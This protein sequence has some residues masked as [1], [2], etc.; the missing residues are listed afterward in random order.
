VSAS[1]SDIGAIRAA[2]QTLVESFEAADPT[3]WVDSYTDDAI[4]V[5]PGMAAI[6]GREALLA[7]ARQMSPLSSARIDAR[8]TEVE[9]DM[10]A[11]LGTASWVSGPRGAE[12]TASRVRFLIVWRREPDGRWRIAREL[13]NADV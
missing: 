8:T 13:L 1:S 12:G 4:F 2:E 3:A 9:G 5:A 6:E 11:T 10:A 7:H